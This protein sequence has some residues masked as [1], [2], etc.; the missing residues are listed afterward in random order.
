MFSLG[1]LYILTN[2]NIVKAF[3][4]PLLSL[5]IPDFIYSAF[6]RPPLALMC[7][8]FSLAIHDV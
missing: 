4:L 2:L 7:K 1:W 3:G 6:V 8:Q 5:I